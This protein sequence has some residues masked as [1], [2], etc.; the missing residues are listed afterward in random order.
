MTRTIPLLISFAALAACQN[1]AVITSLVSKIS[2]AYT[3]DPGWSSFSSART[4]FRAEY[5][6][7][8]TY[9]ED[10]PEFAPSVLSVISTATN[11]A[12][13]Y[14]SIK[15]ASSAAVDE[16]LSIYV[17][18][19]STQSYLQGSA[20]TG[21]HSDLVVLTE[22]FAAATNTGGGSG[23]GEASQTATASGSGSANTTPTPRV[24]VSVS[25]A[26]VTSTRASP[27]PAATSTP[28]PTGAAAAAVGGSGVLVGAVAGLV[29]L[30]GL[31]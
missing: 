6:S 21:L 17:D 26:I 4:S 25:T 29:A 5:Y 3:N 2:T 20:R 30:V 14:S 11:S 27:T 22:I 15:S 7:T 24:I 13:V 28:T 9:Y 19:V 1:N 16:Y 23:E 10:G 18:F 31:L 12:E 8:Q